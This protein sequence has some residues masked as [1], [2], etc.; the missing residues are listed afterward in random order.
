M[1]DLGDCPLRAP[2]FRALKALIRKLVK[3]LRVMSREEIVP[4]YR[5][6][7]PVR[8]PG[9]QVE[10]PGIEP[11]EE[12]RSRP[13]GEMASGMARQRNEKRSDE[14]SCRE[15]NPGPSIPE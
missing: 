7:A 2:T 14:W 10:L 1:A 6:P 12:Q 4:T 13:A 3:E 15:S 5:V 9:D 11:P 8:A